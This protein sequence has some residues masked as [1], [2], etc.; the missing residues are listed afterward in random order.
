[1]YDVDS[2]GEEKR[3]SMDDRRFASRNDALGFAARTRKNLEYIDNAANTGEDV[4]VLTQ[5]INSLLGLVVF[6]HERK[7]SSRFEK[8]LLADL[9]GEGWPHI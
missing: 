1:M 5:L 2:D 6:L 9:D 8:M 4:H 7:L 3:F